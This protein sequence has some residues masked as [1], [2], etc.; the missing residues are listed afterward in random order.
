MSSLI[1][2]ATNLV[3]SQVSKVPMSIDQIL[4]EI[5]KV[6]NALTNLESGQIVAP[7]ESKQMDNKDYFQNKEIICMV[8]GKK[9]F[10]TLGRHIA[11]AHTMTASMYRKQFGIPRTQPLTAKNYS[12]A[13]RKTAQDRGLGDNLAK[14]RQ[15]RMANLELKKQAAAVVDECPVVEVAAAVAS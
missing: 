6:Y 5:N 2:V 13:R 8:C 15:V 14:A 4:S 7:I 10:K 11:T 9:G 12:K 3:T 1:E